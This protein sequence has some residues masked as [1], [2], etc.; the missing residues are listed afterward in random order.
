MRRLGE[1]SEQRTFIPDHRGSKNYIKCYHCKPYG[2]VKAECWSRDKEVHVAEE[3]IEQQ[4]FMVHSDLSN[5]MVG[6][7]EA[8]GGVWL[9]DSGCLTT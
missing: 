4:M 8:P 1:S 6:L 9:V 2:H 3:G 7:C 5:A